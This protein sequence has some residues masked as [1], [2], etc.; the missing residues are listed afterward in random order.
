MKNLH[1]LDVSFILIS[2][3]L[4][5]GL[6]YTGHSEMLGRFSYLILIVGYFSG[7]LVSGY[8]QNKKLKK[9]NNI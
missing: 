1:L 7:K 8:F 4:F 3:L 2:C 6:H 9:D 5:L